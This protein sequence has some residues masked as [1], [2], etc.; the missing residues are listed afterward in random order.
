MTE[1]DHD[2]LVRNLLRLLGQPE[3][4][5][6]QT[7]ISSVI[8]AKDVVYKLKKPVDFG[9]LDYS[10]LERRKHF[11]QEEVRINGRYAPLL[12]LGVVAVTGSVEAPE[13]DGEGAAIEYAVKMRRFDAGAQ[14]DNIASAQGLTGEEC[15]AVADTA[16]AMH[17]GAPV[18]DPDSD[19][20]T[21]ARVVMP[22]Q[23]NFDL[24]ASLHRDG[25][26]AAD[27]AALEQWTRAEHARL[28]LLL[29][30]RRDDGFVR[31]VHGDMHLH[32]MALFEGRPMLF[33]A[34]E[35]NPYLNHIDVISDLA[36]LLMDLEYRG[37]ARQSRRILNR[38]LEH[39]G[40]YAAVALL[41][42]YKTYR[43]MV[44]AKVLA[45]HAAQDIAEEARERVVDEVRAYIALAKS[46]GEKNHPFLMIMHGV[47]ASG[48]STLALEAVEAFGALRL[49]S[50]I[51]R[52]RLFRSEGEEVDIYTAEA[53]AATYGRLEMLAATLLEAGC[54]AVA[55]ATFLAPEQREPFAELAARMGVPFVIL[56]IECSGEELLRRI[57]IRSEKGNDVSEADEA[58][59]AMQQSRVK[60][61]SQP[62]QA[63]RFVLQCD[64]PLPVKALAAFIGA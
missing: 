38:Y 14:L 9:F 8:I 25:D 41:P 29:Q 59:L 1:R 50:D 15:D 58:V 47:S 39:T 40:D 26:L 37:L 6:I 48:K 24:M 46:Y 44:R 45:L 56:D 64:A 42:F 27:V 49:R 60:P 53:T 31:E 5:L 34:I 12:Y 61:L 2:R 16:A 55:D 51:E 33:D 36:F 19:Y 13:L 23:E 57:R 10:T 52:M 18:V 30:R 20:G 22:M 4:S 32:N 43:A 35:F 54:S 7:H 17:D 21:P 28:T 63:Y 11:C 62:E 3:S